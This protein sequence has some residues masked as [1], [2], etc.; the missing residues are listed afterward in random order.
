HTP[1]QTTDAATDNLR[2]ALADHLGISPDDGIDY[3]QDTATVEAATNYLG[4]TIADAYAGLI[5]LIGKPAAGLVVRVALA[6]L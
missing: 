1:Q 2:K 3:T 6:D 5:A 4:A